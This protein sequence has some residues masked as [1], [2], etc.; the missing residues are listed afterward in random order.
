MSALGQHLAIAF[1]RLGI[2]FVI[3]VGAHL[4]QFGRLLRECGYDGPILSFEPVL[5][6]FAALVK[7][8]SDDPRWDAHRIALGSRDGTG[9][10]NVARSTDFSSFLVPN[11]FS[12]QEFDGFTSVDRQ[13]RVPLRRLDSVVASYV[14]ADADLRLFLKIDTQ[15]WELEVLEGA[16]ETLPRVAGLVCEL[17]MKP[18]YEEM[19]RYHELAAFLDARHFEVTD[20]FPVSRASDRTLIDADCVFVRAEAER[21]VA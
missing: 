12:L 10:I 16:E 19:P 7:T 6:V 4:G 11:P 3:D 2:N 14:P 15:G 21:R 5:P 8:C 9:L 17:S 20:I 1:E 18:L 13:E